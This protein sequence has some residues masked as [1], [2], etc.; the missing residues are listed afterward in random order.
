LWKGRDKALN[1]FHG[2]IAG[3]KNKTVKRFNVLIYF[4]NFQGYLGYLGLGW[5]G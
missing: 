4:P 3:A 5:F 2:S 1:C